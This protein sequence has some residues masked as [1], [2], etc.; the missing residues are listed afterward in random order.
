M[1]SNMIFFVAETNQL[2]AKVLY[3]RHRRRDF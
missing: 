3:E 2:R 1:N